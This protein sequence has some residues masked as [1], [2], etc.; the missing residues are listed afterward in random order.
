MMHDKFNQ[1]THTHT[2]T[3]SSI[4]TNM[5]SISSASNSIPLFREDLFLLTE[6]DKRI[7]A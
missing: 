3:Q 5:I 7:I 4:T 2:H 1:N 6:A